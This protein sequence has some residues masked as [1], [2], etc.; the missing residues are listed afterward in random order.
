MSGE[1]KIRDAADAVK[2][3]AE[4]VPVYQDTLQPAA[5]EVGT[6]LQNVAKTIHIALAPISAL[7]WGYE[8]VKDFVSM[9]VAK[10]LQDVP[11]ER[12]TT[13]LPQVA[14]PALEALRYTGHDES[15]R[16]MFAKL[17]ATAM[18]SDTAAE[19]HPSFVDIIRQLSS[20]EAKICR[21]LKQRASYPVVNLYVGESGGRRYALTLISK[22]G[23]E[24]N[25]EFPMMIQRYL[26]NLSRL[27][28]VSVHFD[29]HLKVEL[30]FEVE[31]SVELTP[32]LEKIK[33]EGHT[34]LDR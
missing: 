32:Y 1:N 34:P 17:L 29:S 28:L 2:G 22:L 3:I 6:A 15:L 12:I 20:D 24:A 10:R 13:P 5:R 27:G 30:Y 18:N 21:F 33:I 14:G 25:C 19:A 11:A 7:V 8:K 23:N 4:A 9:S 26:G 16:E 31:G